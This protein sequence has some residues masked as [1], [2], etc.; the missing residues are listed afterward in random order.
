L[1][2]EPGTRCT[3]ILGNRQFESVMLRSELDALKDRYL[4]RFAVHH[5]FSRGPRDDAM[6]SED[7]G[8][9]LFHGRLDAARLTALLRAV[10][11]LAEG[12]EAVVCGPGGAIAAAQT[13]L[14]NIGVGAH[15]IHIERFGND[16]D[17]SLASERASS[18][19]A[20]A[21]PGSAAPTTGAADDVRAQVTVIMDG[22]RREIRFQSTD[23]SILQAGRRSGLDMPYACQSG[24]CSTCKGQV[25]EGEVRMQRNQALTPAEV[26][27]GFVLCCQ[28]EPVST[29]VTLTLDAR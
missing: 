28:A 11:P 29:C 1:R 15:H 22:L 27:Q 23:T 12:D 10:A 19:G 9:A 2:H 18:V 13:A 4:A 24:V 6:P 7:A 25:L 5:V 8:E 14:A 3:L 17:K 26:D 16:D 21:I 20:P